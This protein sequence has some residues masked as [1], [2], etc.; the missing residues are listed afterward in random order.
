MMTASRAKTPTWRMQ[1]KSQDPY[2]RQETVLY[3]RTNETTTGQ[4]PVVKQQRQRRGVQFETPQPDELTHRHQQSSSKHR[5]HS[6]CDRP[7]RA[8]ST[9]AT[10]QTRT[11]AKER[12]IG[13]AVPTCMTSNRAVARWH[14]ND[15]HKSGVNKERERLQRPTETRGTAETPR[16]KELQYWATGRAR[17]LTQRPRPRRRTT[18]LL[19]VSTSAET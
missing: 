17:S 19:Y 5:D 7:Q 1:A 8:R 12:A 9:A 11:R 2:A 14:P 13:T 6:E 15:G 10:T 16:L 4:R 3:R 18:E